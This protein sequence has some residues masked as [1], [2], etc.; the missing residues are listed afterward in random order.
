M[1]K[2]RSRPKE[3]NLSTPP[4]DR[5]N[6]GRCCHLVLKIS[7][8]MLSAARWTFRLAKAVAVLFILCAT[9]LEVTE[10]HDDLDNAAFQAG[11]GSTIK[12]GQ[13]KAPR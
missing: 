9:L 6:V 12:M 7:P 1:Q 10:S 2:V 8:K 5:L 13:A 4:I 3:L 11:Q